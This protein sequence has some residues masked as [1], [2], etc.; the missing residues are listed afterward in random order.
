MAPVTRALVAPLA[1]LAGA[2]VGAAATFVH[3]R[4]L[5]LV[6]ALVATL[7]TVLALPPGWWSRL[8]F[9]LGWMG[10]VLYFANPRA[11]GD[12]LVAADAS[13]Y[14]LLASGMAVVALGLVTVRG[15]PRPRV[16]D[17]GGTVADLS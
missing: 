6:L 5:G 9:V 3:G 1:L 7:A 10:V 17:D 12:Y 14:V 13:G 4:W 2:V 8:P 11:E 15:S 16:A